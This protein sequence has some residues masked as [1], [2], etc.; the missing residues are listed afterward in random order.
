MVT[1]QTYFNINPKLQSYEAEHNCPLGVINL[2][3]DQRAGLQ[4]YHAL[5]RYLLERVS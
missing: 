1:V 2:R 5:E 4:Y 3:L